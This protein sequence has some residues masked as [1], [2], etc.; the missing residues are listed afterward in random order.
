MK[1]ATMKDESVAMLIESFIS[2]SLAF[3]LP[4][5]SFILAFAIFARHLL[6]ILSFQSRVVEQS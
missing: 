2:H 3:I 1:T 4:P 6:S 5:S